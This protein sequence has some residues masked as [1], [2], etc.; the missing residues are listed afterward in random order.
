M[1]RQRFPGAWGGASG[2]NP[3]AERESAALVPHPERG[4]RR[5]GGGLKLRGTGGMEGQPGCSSSS[6]SS[7]SGSSSGGGGG[8]SWPS[9]GLQPLGA[10]G[11][12]GPTNW[13]T[14][15]PQFVEMQELEVADS[16]QVYTAFLV[17][18]DL[19]EG[20][21]WHEVKCVG[22]AE[23][24]LICLYGQEKEEESFQAVV[25]M[26]VHASLSHE[27]IREIMTHACKLQ[28][29]PDSPMSITLAI[30]ESDSTIV[31]YRLTDGFVIP[32]PPEDEGVAESKHWKK[33]KRKCVR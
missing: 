13:M 4:R 14:S 21:N 33:K 2:L 20:R 29:E 7:S 18:L 26:S 3:E 10:A 17:Y 12:D 8:R 27:R 31:Y 19:L 28:Q 32:E 6:S 30:V 23:V 22:L 11:G 5:T 15:H 16:S 25:P 24:Q 9:Q 1:W